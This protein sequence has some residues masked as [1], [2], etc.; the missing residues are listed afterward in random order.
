MRTDRIIAGARERNHLQSAISHDENGLRANHHVILLW[1]PTPVCFVQSVRQR[2]WTRAAAKLCPKKK[3]KTDLQV[4][5]TRTL[6]VYNVCNN[7]YNLMSVHD[8]SVCVRTLPTVALATA[9][10]PPQSHTKVFEKKHDI[11]YIFHIL[12]VPFS[13]IINRSARTPH[14]GGGCIQVT[15]TVALWS[16]HLHK[17]LSF[18]CTRSYLFSVDI[19]YIIY[20]MYVYTSW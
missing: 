10:V 4:N 16:A 1:V 6:H 9:P 20:Y 8:Y 5:R 2:P 13:R 17:S 15:T 14:C 12:L 7:I 11:Y 3:K 18:A 19:N